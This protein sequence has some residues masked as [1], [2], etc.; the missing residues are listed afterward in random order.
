[1]ENYYSFAGLDLAVSTR[2]E[3]MYKDD[4]M[5]APFR[6]SHVTDP[7]RFSFALVEELT[8]PSGDLIAQMETFVVYCDGESRQRYSGTSAGV[9]YDCHLRSV[10]RGKVHE[11]QLKTKTFSNGLT[12]TAVLRTLEAE[13]LIAGTGGFVLHSSFIDIGGKA[14]LFTA[15]SG[16]GKSTQAEL[17]HDLRSARIINGDRSIVRCTEEGVFVCGIPFMGSSHYC[18]N[19]TLPLSGIVYLS[20]APQTSIRRLAGVEAFRRVWEGITVNAWDK[21]DM[22]AVMDTLSQVLSAVPVWHLSC[23]PD[24]TAVVALEQ[25]LRK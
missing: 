8:P 9:W 2:D 25:Q 18:E 17:W 23:T 7:H 10:Q 15:P 12:P 19:V 5:L 20:Q 11:I 14:I 22:S 1:M 4:Q 6:V 16:T 3:W 24:E 13:H 21:E